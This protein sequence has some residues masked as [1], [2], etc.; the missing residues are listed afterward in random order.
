MEWIG[1]EEVVK[2]L[3]NCVYALHDYS[4]YGF[5]TGEIYEGTQTQKDKLE[6]QYLRKE[7][8]MRKNNLPA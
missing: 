7:E 6:R 2:D 1:F 5:P 3:P 4:M 8:F